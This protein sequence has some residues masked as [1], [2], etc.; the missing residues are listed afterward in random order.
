MSGRDLS[1]KPVTEEELKK[2]YQTPTGRRAVLLSSALEEELTSWEIRKKD[3]EQELNNCYDLLAWVNSQK[4]DTINTLSLKCKELDALNNKLFGL[5]IPKRK[6]KRQIS[7]SEL[8][9]EKLNQRGKDLDKQIEGLNEKY[10]NH[11]KLR[12]DITAYE[13]GIYGQNLFKPRY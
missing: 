6:L 5:F 4:A 8:Y 11:I 9:L 7:E 3:I 10:L 13:F 12:P 1:K 2:F